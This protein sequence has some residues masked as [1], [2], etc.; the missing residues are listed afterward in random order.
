MLTWIL[1]QNHSARRF[2]EALGGLPVREK[3]IPIGGIIL[4]E[5][6]Y[7]WTDISALAKAPG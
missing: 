3:D 2:Y 4:E 7:G 5:V 1:A 6:A